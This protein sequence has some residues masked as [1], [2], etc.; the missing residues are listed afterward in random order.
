MTRTGAASEET[1]PTPAYPQWVPPLNALSNYSRLVGSKEIG[2]G[3]N[4]LPLS[5]QVT[6]N[7]LNNYRC[8]NSLSE[9]DLNVHMGICR[10]KLLQNEATP[11]HDHPPA[12]APIRVAMLPGELA[13]QKIEEDLVQ[14]NCWGFSLVG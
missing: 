1:W 11:C 10:K 4:L 9:T 13:A 2:D 6:Q 8:K 12:T 7:K 5:F 14:R 3:A